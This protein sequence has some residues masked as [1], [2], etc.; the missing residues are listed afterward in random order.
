MQEQEQWKG[1]Y[2]GVT[3]NLISWAM[4]SVGRDL[5]QGSYVAIWAFTADEISEKQLNGYHFT[6]LESKE[7]KALNLTLILT[8]SF[9]SP[10]HNTY[11]C[12]LQ[13]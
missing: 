13:W 4:K 1:A 6:D 9:P 11:V 5:E 3:G 12:K 2:L 7:R 8:N 10:C